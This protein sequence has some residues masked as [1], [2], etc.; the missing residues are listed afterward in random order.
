MSENFENY[1]GE[2]RHL[3]HNGS[4]FGLFSKGTAQVINGEIKV[5][6]DGKIEDFRVPNGATIIVPDDVRAFAEKQGRKNFASLGA[7]VDNPFHGKNEKIYSVSGL[8]R[9]R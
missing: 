3:F 1:T 4:I 5:I 7:E 6:V 8:N 2:T 9:K